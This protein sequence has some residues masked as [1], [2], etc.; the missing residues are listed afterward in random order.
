MRTRPAD[1]LSLEER[2][3]AHPQLLDDLNEAELDA[4]LQKEWR[5]IAR[6]QQLLPDD[7]WFVFFFRGGRGAGKTLSAA[8]GIRERVPTIR[9][10][11]PEDESVNVGFVGHRLF[12]D[13]RATMFEGKTGILSVL[14]PSE[15]RGG[16]V[17]TAFNRGDVELWLAD[18][19][20]IRGFSS[21][22]PGDLRG[23]NLH[24]AWVDEPAKFKDAAEGMLEDTTWSNLMYALRE[25]PVGQAIVTGTPTRT[26]LIKQIIARCEKNPEFWRQVIL[27]T[28]DNLHNLSE[29]YR[30]EVVEPAEGTRLGRQELFAELLD[31]IGDMFEAVWFTGPNGEHLLDKAPDAPK[32]LRYWDEAASVPMDGSDPDFTVGVRCSLNPET[33]IYVIEH[34]ERFRA[35]PG[36]RDKQIREISVRDGLS[37]MFVEQ[38]PGASGKSRIA[39]LGRQLDGVCRVKGVLSSGSKEKRAEVTAG[40]AEQGRVRCVRGPWLD[41]LIEEHVEFPNGPHDDIVDAVSGAFIQLGFR[42]PGRR[43]GAQAHTRTVPQL[44]PGGR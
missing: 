8:N 6:P 42:R 29:H 17:A 40:A 12:K 23:P 43:A 39:D 7:D 20:Y 16:S 1:T 22:S 37:T 28:H 10:F 13:V 25:P 35:L 31:D 2:L 3:A 18:G 19:T 34:V 21:E 26:L 11:L 24:L 15:L 4:L 5:V 30:R 38:E 9:A 36:E 33:G 14:P 32:R 44:I 41:A 27:P